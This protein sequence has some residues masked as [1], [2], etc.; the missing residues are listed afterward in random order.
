LDFE[1]DYA[2]KLKEGKPFVIK[3]IY[4]KS[5]TKSGGSLGILWDAIESFNERIVKERL[6][7]LGISPEVLTPVV[8]E[9]TNIADEEKPVQVSLPCHFHDA[10]DLIASG[11]LL[12]LRTLWQGK[13]KEI[14]L[15]LCLPP[16]PADFPFFSANI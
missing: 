5:Q 1:K 6:N 7:S 14:L 2:S 12:R 16:N 9:E 10:C 3:L 15:N 4:D 8:I 11:V 13:K